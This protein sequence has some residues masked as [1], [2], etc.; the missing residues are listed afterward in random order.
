MSVERF[1]DLVLLMF[2]IFVL[3]C[4]ED[5]FSSISFDII[6]LKKKSYRYEVGF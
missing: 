4:F 5:F 6:Y 3:K 2:L 1:R